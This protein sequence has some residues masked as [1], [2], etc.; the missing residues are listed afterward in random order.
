MCEL[1]TGRSSGFW[2]RFTR[3]APRTIAT[4]WTTSMRRATMNRGEGVTEMRGITG[5]GVTEVRG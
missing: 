3:I 4:L 1:K 5:E 2:P